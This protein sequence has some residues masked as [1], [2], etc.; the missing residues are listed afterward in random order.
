MYTAVEGNMYKHWVVYNNKYTKAAFISC[1]MSHCIISTVSS[2][3][4]SSEFYV[5]NYNNKNKNADFI[6]SPMSHYY[7][8]QKFNCLYEFK[9]LSK[10]RYTGV[11]E[12]V[13]FP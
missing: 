11:H 10:I 6:S 1:P 9:V 5:L 12:I 3:V 8:H 13:Y 2:A 7:S 4:V